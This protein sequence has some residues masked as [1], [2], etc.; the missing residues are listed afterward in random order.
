MTCFAPSISLPHPHTADTRGNI[1]LRRHL[2]SPQTPPPKSKNMPALNATKDYYAV[3]GLPSP[4]ASLA[5]LTFTL[6]AADV[7]AEA[8]TQKDITAAYRKLSLI[9]H[10]DRPGGDT[11]KFK[12]I[13]EAYE[14]LN[15]EARRREYDVLRAH[16]AAKG[17]TQQTT[18]GYGPWNRAGAGTG[19]ST[20]GMTSQRREWKTK[21]T[22]QTS[23]ESK[24]KKRAGPRTWQ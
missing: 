19:P 14:I 16:A 5:T 20:G 24:P 10:P 6:S 1:P 23:E 3:L 4:Y 2:E 12:R 22:M 15:D 7:A 8:V 9:L 18:Y 17:H 13:Q 11:E 21:N